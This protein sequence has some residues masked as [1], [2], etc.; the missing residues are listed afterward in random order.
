MNVI[1]LSY[2]QHRNNLKNLAGL[3]LNV[4]LIVTFVNINHKG[5]D[6]IQHNF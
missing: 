5:A 1:S 6:A 4:L 2:L 3:K